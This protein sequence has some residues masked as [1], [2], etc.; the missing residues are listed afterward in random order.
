MA[1]KQIPL[2]PDVLAFDIKTDLDG[3]TFGFRFDY[4]R[5][6]E[7]WR[8]NIED[9]EGNDL[10]VGIP[11]QTRVDL[12]GQ[13]QH[14]ADLPQGQLFVVNLEDEWAN[15]GIYDLQRNAL[16]LYQEVDE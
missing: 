7:Q 11:L 14:D 3:R 12:I 1:L 13:Y 2:T 4:N 6:A 10:L 9:A 16:L 15:P 8:F 5:R